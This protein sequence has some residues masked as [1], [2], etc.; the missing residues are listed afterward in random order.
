MD[1]PVAEEGKTE[2]EQRKEIEA[3][4]MAAQA[5]ILEMVGDLHHADEKPPDNVLFVCKLNPDLEIIFS[6]FGKIKCCEIIRDRK[7]GA[8][9]Q[10]A[11]IEFEEVNYLLNCLS[12]KTKAHC[13]IFLLWIEN[14]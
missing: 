6:R 13:A 4:D 8:S 1:Q 9:L 3:K 14:V 10:Y 7:T 11:F 2:E 12:F 5:Q